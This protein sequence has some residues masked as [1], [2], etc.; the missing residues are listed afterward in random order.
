MVELEEHE[1]QHRLIELKECDHHSVVHV[2]GQ[3]LAPLVRHEPCHLLA[4]HFSL[5]VETLHGNEG[6]LQ[7]PGLGHIRLPFKAQPAGHLNLVCRNLVAFARRKDRKQIDHAQGIVQV[8]N[9]V[10][11][12]WVPLAN[13]TV[14]CVTGPAVVELL[15]KLQLL[16]GLR[17]VDFAL[18]G[19]DA[20]ENFQQGLMEQ[21]GEILHV[22]VRF[23][24]ALRFLPRLP[25]V[26]SFQYA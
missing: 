19:F 24:G 21:E 16:L 6:L 20:P 15:S 4:G 13:E 7:R 11:E 23:R 17:F 1:L 12:G 2:S 5:V 25:R 26:N 18:E 14:Q 8:A 9:C 3:H 22:V 10:H